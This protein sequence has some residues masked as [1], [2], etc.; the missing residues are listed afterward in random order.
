MT[1]F[2]DVTLADGTSVL[3]ELS[4]L[5][6]ADRASSD[7]D[8]PDG[9][10]ELVAVGRFRD[11]ASTTGEALRDAL[12]PLGGMLDLVHEGV[13]SAVRPPDEVEVEFGVKLSKDLRLGIVAAGAEAALVVRAKWRLGQDARIPAQADVEAEPRVAAETH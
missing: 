9:S 10:G 13:R 6:P 11:A 7:P 8:L 5:R 1:A 2:T 3:L 12:R 4:E